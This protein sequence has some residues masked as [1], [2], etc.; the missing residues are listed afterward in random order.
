MAARII[1]IDVG[2]VA[3]S[4]VVVSAGGAIEWS[5]YR[6]HQGRPAEVLQALS[7]SLVEEHPDLAKGAVICATDETPAFVAADRRTDP[8]VAAVRTCRHAHPDARALL[9]VGGERFFLVRFGE[10]GSYRSIRGSSSCAAGTGSFLDQQARRLDL[11]PDA[12]QAT[13]EGTAEL[14][15]RALASTGTT[16]Q[17]ASRCS[18]FA[19]TDLIHAQQEGY[20]LDQICNGL[21]QGLARNLV[22]T[23]TQDAEIPRPVVF[24]GG[25]SRNDAVRS[26]IE[27]IVDSD[28]IVDDFGH[29]YGALGAALD[30]FQTDEAITPSEGDLQSRLCE[31]QDT[32]RSYQYDPLTLTRSDY[33]DFS[34]HQTTIYRATRVAGTGDNEGKI[35]EVDLY[36]PGSAG[37][38]GAG[39][40]KPGEASLPPTDGALHVRVGIDVGSTSTKAV[41]VDDEG[42]VV[43]GYYT[44]TSG[45]PVRAVQALFDAI[46]ATATQEGWNLEVIGAA[47]TGSG[48]SFVGAIVGA[49]LVLDEITAHAR[50]ATEIDPEVDT[51]IEIGGQDAKFT[52]LKNGVVTFSQM[53]AVCAAG[54]GSFLEEQAAKLDVKVDAYAEEALN[55]PAPLASD[56]CTVFM[57]R[58]INNYLNRGYSTRE[59]L[60]AALH[61]VRENYLHKV[62]DTAIIGKRVCF[63]GATAKNRALV[64]AFEQKLEQP[65]S[66]S[67]YCH[68]T[69]AYG[70]A[71]V[72]ADE[73]KA[74]VAAAAGAASE[75][76][77]EAAAAAPAAAGTSVRPAAGTSPGSTTFRG[78]DLFRDEVPVETETC[79]YCGN[80]C[81]IRLT[82]VKG[83]RVAYGF[84]CGR[85]YETKGKV[86]ENVSGFDLLKTRWRIWKEILAQQ[87]GGAAGTAINAGGHDNPAKAAPVV[88]IPTGIYLASTFRFWETFFDALAIPTVTS[89]RVKGA[90]RTGRRLAG[91]EFCAPMM[92]LHGQ[93][94]HLLDAADYV[95]LPMQLTSSEDSALRK[96]RS[97]CYYSQLA[98]SILPEIYEGSRRDQFLRPLVRPGEARN[99]VDELHRALAQLRPELS[100]SDVGAAYERA[101][102]LTRELDRRLRA[103]FKALTAAPEDAP[104]EVPKDTTDG[105]AEQ[106]KSSPRRRRNFDVVLLGRP[107]TI[108]S[109]EMNQRIPDILGKHGVRA[110]YQ[111]MVP[112]S[113]ADRNA[114]DPLLKEIPWSYA[115]EIL[116]TATTCA[117]EDGLYPVL[118]TSF[119]CSPDA[120]IVDYFKRILDSYEKPYLILQL[121]DH[122]S[123]VGYETRIEAALRAFANHHQGRQERPPTAA[124]SPSPSLT[125][126]FTDSMDGK[127]VL[128]PN[129]DSLTNRLIVAGLRSRGI[130]ARLLRED[131]L[132]IQ[133]SMKTNSG[134]CIPVNVIAEESISYVQEEGLDPERTVLWM[135]RSK[136]ACNIP[137]Y[138][139]YIKSLFDDAGVPIGVYSG[140]FTLKDVSLGATY[141][142]YFGYLFGGMLR[143]LG[144]MI[145]PYER[146]PGETNRVLARS[147]AYLEEVFTAR[148]SKSDAWEEVVG[149]LMAVDRDT[150]QR[151]PQ[152]AIF[153]DL[154]VRDNDIANQN[155]IE[156]IEQSGG[157]VVTTPYSDYVKVIATAHFRKLLRQRN[158][159]QWGTLRAVHAVL[160]KVERRFYRPLSDLMP[161]GPNDISDQDIEAELA[162]FNMRPEQSGESVENVL[163]IFH[164]LRHHPQVS[165]FVQASPAF[166]CPSLITESLSSRIRALT[167]VPVVSVTYDGTGTYQNNIV[168]PYLKLAG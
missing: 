47:T 100:R 19:K 69:G 79:P 151:R 154:Y 101:Q 122:D 140:D 36:R 32:A 106:Q 115:A 150:G 3:A 14:S 112:R 65:I 59:I 50:A 24:A 42:E 121:D 85:D 17:I 56:R 11:G 133:R 21:C 99:N 1:G 147:A 22:N 165:L 107:Y 104:K 72:L 58:D 86:S 63:Q 117:Q 97:Y 84:L 40:G 96:S 44:R 82:T 163:K 10:D 109:E 57:E 60:A 124:V 145:R 41:L 128:F 55:V 116:E 105:A 76:S 25:V 35:V 64:A 75:D 95:F 37:S 139:H 62:A 54:T 94:A 130:D 49:D 30:A 138:P 108:L 131:P 9:A 28:L 12:N 80:H 111:D 90:V 39:R 8:V 34:A 20:S 148:S 152:V 2:S 102:T 88:G 162:E 160:T 135:P 126:K 134:Q 120:F 6:F 16:P 114:V 89:D 132:I 159:L 71:L 18:V 164:I 78:L 74:P 142:A 45:A 144:C 92:Q 23:L 77:A 166:C 15:R 149:Q 118:V 53:N 13:A 155:L 26:H 119:K 98:A 167:G 52:T 141:D 51:I 153:G 158:L 43:A 91:A 46:D 103:H 7:A 156:T 66:V 73:A 5:G 4:M 70:A 110:F 68:L 31:P 123:N 137:L 143:R 93:V 29:L 161:E 146:T 136:W 87:R 129:W 67:L 38:S 33:P 48:R 83:K 157:E 61:S 168:I 81:R 27:A 113:R 125:P 127:T